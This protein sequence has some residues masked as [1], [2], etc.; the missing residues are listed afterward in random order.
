MAAVNGV[1]LPMGCIGDS[2][3]STDHFLRKIIECEAVSTVKM[4]AEK[5][6]RLNRAA[7]AFI[8]R[9]TES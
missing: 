1:I 4:P 2:L 6:Q 5:Q 3:A 9:V 7:D 8:D